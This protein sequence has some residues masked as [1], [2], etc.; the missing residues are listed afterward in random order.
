MDA[1]K[2]GTNTC[3]KIIPNLLRWGL[4]KSV[5]QILSALMITVVNTN[6]Y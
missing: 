6:G 5:L 2:K 3:L 4:N 1:Q